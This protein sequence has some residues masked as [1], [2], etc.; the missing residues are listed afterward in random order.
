VNAEELDRLHSALFKRVEELE[1]KVAELQ[2]RPQV[3]AGFV[4]FPYPVYPSW[5]TYPAT[6]PYEWSPFYVTVTTTPVKGL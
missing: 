3:P 1:K 5:P 2:Q 6:P 4:L